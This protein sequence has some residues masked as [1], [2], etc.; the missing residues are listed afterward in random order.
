M[1]PT[2]KPLDSCGKLDQDDDDIS[3]LSQ[4]ELENRIRIPGVSDIISGVISGALA[5][6]TDQITAVETAEQESTLGTKIV[7]ETGANAPVKVTEYVSAAV[8]YNLNSLLTDAVTKRVSA[9]MSKLII[10]R[11]SPVISSISRD[12]ILNSVRH[13]V[14]N[15]ISNTLLRDLNENLVRDL[16]RTLLL[17]LTNTL[18]RSVTHSV[19]PTIAMATSYDAKTDV[20]CRKCFET[21]EASFCEACPAYYS[22]WYANY[23]ADYY[24]QAVRN[25]DKMKYS[26][27]MNQL[28]SVNAPPKDVTGGLVGSTKG[29]V[30]SIIS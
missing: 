27:D 24:A 9:S 2:L 16:S 13:K 7:L 4:V 11:L 30:G 28:E 14:G 26:Q 17:S 22:D 3:P 5:P 12:R 19:V 6:I 21:S 10:D 15:S 25:V 29:A 8:T 18:T 20:S 1:T 23:Y